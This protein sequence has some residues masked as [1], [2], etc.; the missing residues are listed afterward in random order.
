MDC[1]NFSHLVAFE[2]LTDFIT[3]NAILRELWY[4]MS[5][6]SDDLTASIFRVPS[7]QQAERACLLDM[8]TVRSAETSVILSVT[9]EKTVST[10]LSSPLVAVESERNTIHRPTV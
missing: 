8:E 4:N 10:L 1:R 7:K 6:V 3:N 2:F 9:S 5:D